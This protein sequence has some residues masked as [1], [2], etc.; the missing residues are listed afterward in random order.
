MKQDLILAENQTK[1]NLDEGLKLINS[2][3]IMFVGNRSAVS[4]SDQP[5]K[6]IFKDAATE[7]G[8]IESLAMVFYS[9]SHGISKNVIY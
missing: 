5:S 2:S 9:L 6:P 8:T 3:F 1:E 4:V 7:I